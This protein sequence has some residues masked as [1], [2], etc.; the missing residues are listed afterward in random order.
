MGTAEAIPIW[1]S[2]FDTVEVIPAAAL[3][4]RI[5]A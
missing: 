4:T 1:Y 5:S 2:W 3:V